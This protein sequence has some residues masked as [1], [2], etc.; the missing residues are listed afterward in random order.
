M[1]HLIWPFVVLLYQTLQSMN[2]SKI[3]IWH[4]GFET[5]ASFWRVLVSVS[6]NLVWNKESQFWFRKLWSRSSTE[7]W[8]AVYNLFTI[9]TAPHCINCSVY[10]YTY[11]GRKVLEHYLNGLRSSWTKCWMER[12]TGR[13]PSYSKVSVS[14]LV[15]RLLPS[16][17]RSRFRYQKFFIR[18]KRLDFGFGKFSPARP[19][20]CMHLGIG[21]G[22]KFGLVIQCPRWHKAH[23]FLSHGYYFSS[24]RVLNEIFLSYLHFLTAV[25]HHVSDCVILGRLGKHG[26]P[27]YF[28]FKLLIYLGGP[29]TL[30]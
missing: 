26:C 8:T 23:F 2:C 30:S 1:G 12:V 25:L 29:S 13:Y 28:K 18:K 6:E 19:P 11:C 7:L 16:F 14:V 17:W 24:I 20:G 27:D 4:F 22:Q 9:Q 21:F 3:K 5:F 15:P 10:A